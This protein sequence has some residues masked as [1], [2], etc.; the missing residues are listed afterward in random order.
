MSGCQLGGSSP[1]PREGIQNWDL[2]LGQPLDGKKMCLELQEH[3]QKC[4]LEKGT[5][6]GEMGYKLRPWMGPREDLS[7]LWSSWGPLPPTP[8]HTDPSIP[9]PRAMEPSEM[10]AV[11][12]CPSDS[13][14]LEEPPVPQGM[15][16]IPRRAAS[17][18]P[19][20]ARCRNHGVTAHLKGHKRLCLFQACECHKCVLIL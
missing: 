13:G 19:T 20:C 17:R 14:P 18:S 1:P 3:R 12:Q 5:R 11:L 7:P 16:L 10:P 6:R 4:E 15:E 9:V 2:G 8:G